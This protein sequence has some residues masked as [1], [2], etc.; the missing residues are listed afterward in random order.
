MTRLPVSAEVAARITARIADYP[1]EAPEKLRWLVPYVARFQALPLY[2]GW[3]ET[4][5]I[6]PDGEL[7]R[8]ST[9]GDYEGTREVEDPILARIGLVEG[10]KQS[11]EFLP[12]I[13]GRPPGATTCPDCGGLG[14]IPL[15]PNVICSCGGV[16]W[17]DA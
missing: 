11:A 2:I 16:G 5:G 7:V 14:Y 4:V 3:T 13:P 9:E 1:A 12:L 6:R 17:R 8:W 10:A 15:L